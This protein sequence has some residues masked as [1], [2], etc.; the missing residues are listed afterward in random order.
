M[1]QD[2]TDKL[3]H[4]VTDSLVKKLSEGSWINIGYGDVKIG[5]ESLKEIY[6]C[7]NMEEVKKR[8]VAKLEDHLADKIVVSM[9]T[10]FNNDV[11]SIMSNNTLRQELR[12]LIRDNIRDSIK[13]GE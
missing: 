5:T 12:D 8:C 9:L 1:S 11:K 6:R 3:I 4:A 7:I 2:L 13:V 10:E